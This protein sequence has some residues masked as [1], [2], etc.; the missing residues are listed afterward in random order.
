[1]TDPGAHQ[2]ASQAVP[3]VGVTRAAGFTPARS[4]GK[5]SWAELEAEAQ[6]AFFSFLFLFSI[7]FPL[8]PKFIFEFR[9]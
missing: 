6:I 8:F 7:S 9:I 5:W 2:S 3:P 1:V 4:E